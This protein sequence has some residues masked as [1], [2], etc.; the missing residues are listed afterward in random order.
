[1]STIT[2]TTPMPTTTTNRWI[3]Y[4][5]SALP[6]LFL[7]MDGAMKIANIQPVIEASQ[8]LGLPVDSAPAIGGLL[9]AC[10]LVYLIPQTAVLG[11]VLLTG[12][13]GGALAMQV[14]VEAPLFSLIF[15]LLLGALLWAGLYL[16]MPQLRA[17]LPWKR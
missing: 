16:R 10:V 9:L 8:Q 13:L 7:I 1:M 14:R 11:A 15:P 12:F 2:H 6:V 4:G 5:L 17:L 3:S